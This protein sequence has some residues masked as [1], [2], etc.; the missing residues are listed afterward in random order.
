MDTKLAQNELLDASHRLRWGGFEH[1]AN[2]TVRDGVAQ[3]G[4]QIGGHAVTQPDAADAILSGL[5]AAVRIAMA[6]V[7]Q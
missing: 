5:T 1:F 7:K 3:V 6:P 4:H 2:S